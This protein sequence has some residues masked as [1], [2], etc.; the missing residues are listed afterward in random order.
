[1][2]GLSL[3]KLGDA[4]LKGVTAVVA[5]SYVHRFDVCG[6]IPSSVF[7]VTLLA[8]GSSSKAVAPKCKRGENTLW[9]QSLVHVSGYHF[10]FSADFQKFFQW[11]GGVLR[12]FTSRLRKIV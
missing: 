4:G 11:G 12:F 10:R 2:I 8:P 3:K 7:S 6:I 9:F 5:I 1:M